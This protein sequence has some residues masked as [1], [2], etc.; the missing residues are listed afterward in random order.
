MLHWPLVT[1]Q[2]ILQVKREVINI[3]IKLSYNTVEN[4][5][6]PPCGAI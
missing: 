2:S 3:N 4:K 5:E 6:A 1:I